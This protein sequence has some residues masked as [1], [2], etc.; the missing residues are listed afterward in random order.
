MI[1]MLS[2]GIFTPIASMPHWAEIL[3][4]ANPIRYFA[5]AMRSIFLKGAGLRD[6]CLTSFFRLEQEIFCSQQQTKSVHS[7]RGYPA[8]YSLGVI[9]VWVLKNLWND[10]ID[11]KLRR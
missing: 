2:S 1:F 8:R 4:Y 9:P 11:W 5:D 3:T 6:N 7:T 10:G